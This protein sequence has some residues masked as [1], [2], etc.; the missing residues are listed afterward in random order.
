MYLDGSRDRINAWVRV[1]LS[2]PAIAD[3][4][5][6]SRSTVRYWRERNGIVR[7]RMDAEAPRLSESDDA[8]K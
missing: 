8:S 7:P 5:R 2:D 4:V 1:G 3:R 6:V